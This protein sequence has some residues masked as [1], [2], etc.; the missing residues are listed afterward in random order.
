M[1]LITIVCLISLATTT[2]DCQ[3]FKGRG[4]VYTKQDS[5]SHYLLAS[6]VHWNWTLPAITPLTDIP[7]PMIVRHQSVPYQLN[8]NNVGGPPL[9]RINQ[10]LVKKNWQNVD[11]RPL[12]HFIYSIY[13]PGYNGY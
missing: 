4:H 12:V 9:D 8:N 10:Y 7:S 11:L 1:K 13:Q 5:A 3:Y 2:A 6:Y